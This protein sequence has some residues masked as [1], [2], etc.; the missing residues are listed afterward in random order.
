MFNFSNLLDENL[1]QM[2]RKIDEMPFGAVEEMEKR[3]LLPEGFT[4]NLDAILYQASVDS[5]F[6]DNFYK[7]KVYVS[8]PAAAPSGVQLKQGPK[9]GL[10]YETD[11]VSAK[12]QELFTSESGKKPEYFGP[13]PPE[14]VEPG[15]YAKMLHADDWEEL[16]ELSNTLYGDVDPEVLAGIKTTSEEFAQG[17]DTKGLNI[18]ATTEEYM[19]N[20]K[21]DF[22]YTPERQELHNSIVKEF[23]G[24][25]DG[26]NS[27]ARLFD[28]DKPTVILLGG[29]PGAG[30]TSQL[31]GNLGLF[32]PDDY[33]NVA[34]DEIKEMLP[35]FEGWNSQAVHLESKDVVRKILDYGIAKNKNLIID[36]TLKTHKKADKLVDVFKEKGYNVI[37]YGMF[38]KPSSSMVRAQSRFET[39][40][41]FM[42]YDLIASGSLQIH[43]SIM[44]LINKPNVDKAGIWSNEVERGEMPI[45]MFEKAEVDPEFR[46]L[47]AQIWDEMDQDIDDMMIEAVLGRAPIVKSTKSELFSKA[48][49]VK[50]NETDRTFQV[51]ASVDVIDRQGERIP[52]EYLE[53][54]IPAWINRG[55]FIVDNHSNRV[56]GQATDY[57]FKDKTMEDGSKIAG[58]LID[59]FIFRGYTVDDDVWER[60]RNDKTEGASV[61]GTALETKII[62]DDTKCEKLLGPIEIYELTIA[63]DTARIVNPESTITGHNKMAKS[64]T[65]SEFMANPQ[66]YAVM[67][68]ADRCPDCR[69]ARKTLESNKVDFQFYDVDADNGAAQ[70][71]QTLSKG[72]TKI[73]V[74]IIDG[75]VLV[76][77]SD[78]ELLEKLAVAHERGETVKIDATGVHQYVQEDQEFG[79]QT[80]IGMGRPKFWKTDFFKSIHPTDYFKYRARDYFD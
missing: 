22:E 47:I 71:A 75:E 54:A 55:G 42:P 30:K 29:S 14:G 52:M 62:C 4:K 68:G 63:S 70:K 1:M 44:D 53:E 18:E 6:D 7:S 40:G 11:G 8:G 36:R 41:R 50:L 59:A 23:L 35:E 37:V 74:I 15:Q 49:V 77:P 58:V 26:S 34:A 46:A 61:G 60:I 33:L 66:P 28:N 43:D 25:H 24:S 39:S 51:W 17:L 73:P 32:D 13:D 27:T 19:Q 9:G 38:V 65:G 12:P 5:V 20:R 10:Y 67:Y 2:S 79:G 64:D 56:V 78:E 57:K 69:R 3:G 31:A 21:G 16:S 80:E 45:P 48:V 72:N 76:E